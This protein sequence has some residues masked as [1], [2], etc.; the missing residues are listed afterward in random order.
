MIRALVFA[1][2][3]CACGATLKPAEYA[4][5]LEGCLVASE[6]CEQYVACRSKVA[7]KYGREFNATCEK[8]GGN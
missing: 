8:D 1:L 5:E 7:S 4:A 6:T 2:V 3:L